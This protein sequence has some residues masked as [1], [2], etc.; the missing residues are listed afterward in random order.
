MTQP[1][2]HLRPATQADF[3]A[4]TAIY[5]HHVQHGTGTFETVPPSHSD[6]LKRWDDVCAK[7]L[8]WLCAERDG[9]VIGFAYANWFRPREAFRFCAEDSVYIAPEAI[10]QGLGRALLVE[11]MQQCEAVGI[12]KMVAVVGDSANV[13]SVSLHQAVGFSLAT[14]LPACGWKQDRWLDIVILE[15]WLGTGNSTPPPKLQT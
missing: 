10:G 14:T 4:I 7:G 13:G 3:E 1:F 5:S 8:P 9:K 11:L 2:V 6:M 15:R 12:R